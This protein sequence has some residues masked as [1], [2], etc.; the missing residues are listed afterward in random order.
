[1][2]PQS[3]ELQVIIEICTEH[4]QQLRLTKYFSRVI[5]LPY[6]MPTFKNCASS[7]GWSL[8]SGW[9]SEVL[10][11]TAAVINESVRMMRKSG[12]GHGS[13]AAL[14][15]RD[16]IWTRSPSSE[17]KQLQS[18]QQQLDMGLVPLL[19]NTAGM[20]GE[21]EEFISF[22]IQVRSRHEIYST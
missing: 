17:S 3:D 11:H 14:Q 16:S 19:T 20:L 2:I 9:P 13:P 6:K 18:Q 8:F 4:G 7:F 1:M 5:D 10:L 21:T 15:L 12:P 22:I